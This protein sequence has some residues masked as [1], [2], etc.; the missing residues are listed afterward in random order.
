M[1]TAAGAGGTDHPAFPRSGYRMPA[2][3]HSERKKQ[4]CMQTKTKYFLTKKFKYILHSKGHWLPLSLRIAFSNRAL[5]RC[6]KP[7]SGIVA[8]TSLPST[9]QDKGRVTPRQVLAPRVAGGRDNI[10]DNECQQYLGHSVSETGLPLRSVGAG[11]VECDVIWLLQGQ[12]KVVSRV[13]WLLYHAESAENHTPT[14][15]FSGTHWR[16]EVAYLRSH[17]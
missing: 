15:R 2:L 1:A 8:W 4:F 6:V 11:G 13:L 16:G 9:L 14:P 7:V 5:I 10:S 3:S 12:R 17:S